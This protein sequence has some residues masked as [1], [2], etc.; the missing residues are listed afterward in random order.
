MTDTRILWA[1]TKSEL[2][3][4]IQKNV[5]QI[6]R[7]IASTNNWLHQAFLDWSNGWGSVNINGWV[8]LKQWNIL[9]FKNPSGSI[10]LSWNISG[11]KTII[12]ENANVYIDGNI[13]WDGNLWIIVLRW[14]VWWNV[15]IDTAVTDIHASIFAD[16]SIVSYHNWSV[17]DWNTS[18]DILANQL[19]IY[20]SV[21]SENTIWTSRSTT[22]ICPFYVPTAHCDIAEAQKYDLN[23][24]RRYF[25]STAINPSGIPSGAE[26][27]KRWNTDP[28]LRDFPVI[29]EYNPSIQTTPPPLFDI[30]K[31]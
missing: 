1:M 4:D 3:R 22:P 6:T 23:Y 28:N 8:L 15:Y 20:G 2:R 12:V 26:S 30:Q 21:F 27:I 16:R 5:A 11:E 14:D 31:Q 18:A 19:Y 17:L 9:Y 29:I 13:L 7:N 24:L 10:K 25:L